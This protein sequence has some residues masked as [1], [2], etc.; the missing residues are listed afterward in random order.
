MLRDVIALE[1]SKILRF[2]KPSGNDNLG[3]PC[4][5]HKGG[6]EKNPSFF[7]NIHTGVFFCHTCGEKGTFVQLLK[8]T[9]ASARKVDLINELANQ[10]KVDKPQKPRNH[11]GDFILNESLLGVFDY[12]P[13]KLVK[14]GFDEKLLHD[15]DVGFDKKYMRITF[16]IRDGH[17]NLIGISGRT[18]TGAY[19]RYLVYRD[20][21]LARFAPDDH[22]NKYD[23]YTIKNRDHLWN[24]HNVFPSLFHN[25]LD[26]LIVVEGY[27]A[28]IWMLQNGIENVVALMGSRMTPSQESLLCKYTKAVFLAL[29]Y[30]DAGIGGTFEIG[31]QLSRR[32]IDVYVFSY[33]NS[34]EI[35]AQPD[36]LDKEEIEQGLN[37]APSFT[38]WRNANGLYGR[39]QEVFRSTHTWI[40]K[41]QEP[42][43]QGEYRQE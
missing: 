30:N 29:D 19:P 14:D 9:G 38:E 10:T 2:V 28:C 15:L 36:N 25:K 5:F 13:T 18:V 21:D 17:G 40:R 35:G 6:M 32:G 41:Q 16:P 12:C 42:T 23:G 11:V 22:R 7:V 1:L 4:P 24:F 39:S 20:V 27:K 37:N 34:V 31:K 8:K 3:G 43:S 26:T 33:P